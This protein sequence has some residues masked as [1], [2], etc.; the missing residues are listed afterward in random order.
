MIVHF[1][2]G[3]RTCIRTN[4]GKRRL[5]PFH[6]FLVGHQLRWRPR[7]AKI[8]C[9]TKIA[10]AAARWSSTSRKFTFQALRICSNFGLRRKEQKFEITIILYNSDNIVHYIYIIYLILSLLIY[11]PII[12]PI[13]FDFWGG[14]CQAP[15][16]TLERFLVLA[17]IT[18]N[19]PQ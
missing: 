14:I 6:V 16:W 4:W 11:S 7:G 18:L 19:C 5:G 17:E 10:S 15:K 13:L 2:L 12:K 3:S 1:F 9:A 8:R